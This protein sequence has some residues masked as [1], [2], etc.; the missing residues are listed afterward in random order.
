M[1]A[2]SDLARIAASHRGDD[3][4]KALRA[5]AGLGKRE[6]EI[7][8]SAWDRHGEIGVLALLYPES[9]DR[10]DAT[11]QRRLIRRDGIEHWV[12]FHKVRGRWE[13]V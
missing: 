8:A 1:R 11:A 6:L 7:R 2:E 13:A 5:A 12:T 10:V 4:Q 9:V 3:A